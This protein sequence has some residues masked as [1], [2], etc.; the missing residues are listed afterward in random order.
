MNQNELDNKVTQLLVWLQRNVEL[1]HLQERN[2]LFRNTHTKEKYQRINS[3]WGSIDFS[4]CKITNLEKLKV[5]GVLNVWYSWNSL[6]QEVKCKVKSARRHI[7]LMLPHARRE[8]VCFNGVL[9]VTSNGMLLAAVMLCEH[10]PYKQ[11]LPAI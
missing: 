8:Q 1:S 7:D 3:F 2:K 10:S 9:Y 4:E 6:Y 5:W 11:N